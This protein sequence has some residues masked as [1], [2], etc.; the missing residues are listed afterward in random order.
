MKKNKPLALALAAFIA[1]AAL[2]VPVSADVGDVKIS[3]GADLTADQRAEVLSLLS[4]TEEDLTQG[5]V[6]YVTNE[7]EHEYLDEYL[8]YD[9]IGDTA[10]SS[11]KVIIRE[12][13]YGIS[14]TTYN[15]S[16]CTTGMYQNALITAGV[17]D[18]EVYIA[19]PANISGTAALIGIMKAYESA[20]D[21]VLD[22]ENVEAATE[23][24]VI[25]GE[26]AEE[27]INS[28]NAELIIAEL[29]TLLNEIKDMDD[30]TI[31]SQIREVAE[32]LG[33]NLS[34]ETVVQIREF[35]KKLSQ[36]DLDAL[37]EKAQ[38]LFES[39][40]NLIQA[41]EEVQ[42]ILNSIGTFFENI[43]STIANWLSGLF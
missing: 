17:K 4:L 24:L 20:T 35:L 5:D 1:T 42:G 18:A 10:L 8:D 38:N 36:L 43:F 13:G 16:Y 29:K 2:A 26:L 31:D 28:E 22:E 40:T 21:E 41:S 19:A 12:E 39:F 34:D 25:T 23:E 15:I 6:I 9:I 14:V 11:S 37:L 32:S 33:E 27:L 3:L 30:V 7:E